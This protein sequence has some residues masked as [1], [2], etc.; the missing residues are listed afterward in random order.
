MASCSSERE[1]RELAVLKG[2]F[3][4]VQLHPEVVEFILTRGI[5]S[6]PDFYGLVKADCY[7]W[8]L[9]AV[10]VTVASQRSNALEVSR[11]KA[12]WRAAKVLVLE[13]EKA[14]MSG[15]TDDRDELSEEQLKGELYQAWDDFHHFH[16]FQFDLFTVPSDELL[17]KLHRE[18]QGCQA[19]VIPIK[20]V[21]SLESA[22]SAYKYVGAYNTPEMDKVYMYFMGLRILGNGYASIGQHQVPSKAHP[23]TSVCF[24]PWQVNAQY[25]EFCLRKVMTTS[26]EPAQ[27]LP[28]FHT[29]DML[30]RTKMVKLMRSGWPQGEA[31]VKAMAEEEFAWSTPP[32]A[33]STGSSTQSKGEPSSKRLK[34]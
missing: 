15:S 5:A 29:R 11:I 7:E 25:A 16:H 17:D 23:G 9:E 34:H 26:M 32:I 21:H 1:A 13:S 6:V 22:V 3:R 10:L 20:K 19:S 31:L 18:V 27:M 24:A 12:A 4:Q 28:W 2:V 33:I 8:N 30:T 14:R